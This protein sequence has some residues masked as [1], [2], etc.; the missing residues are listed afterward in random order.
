MKKLWGVLA[1]L[2]LL[3]GCSASADSSSLPSNEEVT[4]DTPAEV[5]PDSVSQTEA[6]G[7]TTVTVKEVL[8]NQK[9]YVENGNVVSVQGYLPQSVRV[10]DAGNSFLDIQESPD[11]D[12][13]SEWIRLQ[14]EN[15]DFGGCKAVLTGTLFYD[16]DG[17]L[18]LDVTKAQEI[19][20]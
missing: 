9:K 2:V 16:N 15:L 10:D 17:Q 14:A 4:S 11:S 13:E 8:A 19:T 12:N 1:C 6:N 5:T 18:T 3:T 7:E 20:E